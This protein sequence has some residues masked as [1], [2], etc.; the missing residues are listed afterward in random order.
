MKI[1]IKSENGAAIATLSGEIDHHNAKELRAELDRFIVSAQPRQLAIDFG[2]ITFMDSSGI[3]LIMGRS[4]LMKECG[5]AL[6]VL[7]P[8][9]YIR[10]VL[11]LSGIERIVKIR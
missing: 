8:Q 7:N 6:E 2:G 1:D 4:K 3:G 5:G 11:K 9:P 10:R